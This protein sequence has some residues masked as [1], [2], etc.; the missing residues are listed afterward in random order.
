MRF[1]NLEK[2]EE[3]WFLGYVSVIDVTLIFCSSAKGLMIKRIPHPGTDRSVNASSGFI[4][5]RYLFIKIIK[6]NILRQNC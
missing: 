3:R 1:E 2:K 4:F 5:I 6:I